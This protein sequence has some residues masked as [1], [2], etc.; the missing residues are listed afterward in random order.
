VVL[1][2]DFIACHAGP[3]RRKISREILVD[4]R[5]FPDIVHDLTW[6][7]IRTPAFPAGYTGSHVR[8]FRKGLERD[9]DTP[10]LVGHHPCSAD[11]TLWLNAGQINQHHIVISSRPDRVGIFTGIDGE[12]VPQIY[13]VEDLLAWLNGQVTETVP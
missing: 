5:Q 3:A 1:A 9:T 11:G 8:Q 4:A 10:F 7:R 6:N 2:R 12:M 13:P